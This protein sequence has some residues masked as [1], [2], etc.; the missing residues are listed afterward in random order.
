MV[1]LPEAIY[2]DQFEDCVSLRLHFVRSQSNSAKLFSRTTKEEI[3]ISMTI[4]FG[5]EQAIAIPAK[6]P[7]FPFFD[8]KVYFGIRRG[9]LELNLENCL[10][11]LDKVIL[12]QD[13]QLSVEVESQGETSLEVQIGSSSGF[14]ATDKESGKVKKMVSRVQQAGG[15]KSPRWIFIGEKGEP[16]LGRRRQEGL[17]TIEL[18]SKP[19][20]VKATFMTSGKDVW[21]NR[22]RVGFAEDETLS[23]NKLAHIERLIAVNYIGKK[24]DN[25]ISVTSWKY[26]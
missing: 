10:L 15:E 3:D 14:K 6:F 23:S 22:G 7:Y 8:G 12:D 16:L 13:F 18:Q 1:R 11:P 21:I 4:R 5:V 25:P 17:G 24:L 2:H 20:E 26:D 19:C 9:T